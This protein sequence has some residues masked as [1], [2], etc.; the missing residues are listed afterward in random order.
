VFDVES[1]SSPY[2]VVLLLA[3]T[4]ML[5]I[6]TAS[7]LP[8]VICCKGLKKLITALQVGAGTFSHQGFILSM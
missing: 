7:C 1:V 2:A 5:S 6:A 8:M 4:T 3:Q